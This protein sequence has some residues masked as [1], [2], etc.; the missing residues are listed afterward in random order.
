VYDSVKEHFMRLSW[1]S[2][3]GPCGRPV[4]S[5][6]AECGVDINESMSFLARGLRFV[7]NV[8][9]VVAMDYVAIVVIAVGS[10]C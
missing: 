5:F 6:M 8:A 7:L 9:G 1:I 4:V 3:E 10:A 2:L